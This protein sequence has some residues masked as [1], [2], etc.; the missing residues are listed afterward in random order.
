MNEQSIQW[1]NTRKLPRLE[2]GDRITN[3]RSK[4]LT[5]QGDRGYKKQTNR[6]PGNE[7]NNK[8]N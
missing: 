4:R 2:E 8:P 6:N 3:P 1:N 5:L 7:G